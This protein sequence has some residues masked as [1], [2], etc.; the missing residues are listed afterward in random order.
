MKQIRLVK[1]QA[2]AG[3]GAGGFPE[4]PIEGCGKESRAKKGGLCGACDAW[5]R[6]T[7]LYSG[8]QLAEYLWKLGRFA[9]RAR[10]VGGARGRREVA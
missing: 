2:G 4:C 7:Q 1:R 3:A 5:W 9:G 10:R 6:R 8:K